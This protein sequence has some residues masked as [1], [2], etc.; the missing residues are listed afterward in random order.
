MQSKRQ[1]GFIPFTSD[2]RPGVSFHPDGKRLFLYTGKE[3]R[4]WDLQQ[5][6]AIKDLA[7]PY[8]M[9]ANPLQ[10]LGPDI[11]M[12]RNSLCRVGDPTAAW[13]YAPHVAGAGTILS[14]QHVGGRRLS[15]DVRADATDTARG[16]REST[17]RNRVG[18]RRRNGYVT[19][20]ASTVDR[21][22]RRADR[23][24]RNA[25]RRATTDQQAQWVESPSAAAKLSVKVTKGKTQQVEYR[26]FM[27]ADTGTKTVSIQLN[28]T[29]LELTID[30]EKV[31]N[32][33]TTS[34]PRGIVQSKSGQSFQ[35][36]VTEA[37]KPDLARLKLLEL[38]TYLPAKKLRYGRGS[39]SLQDGKW[40]D[41]EYNF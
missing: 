27:G 15:R 17:G 5:H 37:T 39:S 36:A 33:D 26:T 38:P 28:T 9:T 23:P 12:N 22:R 31:W 2:D 6:V 30:G 14:T 11:Y 7:M 24:G 1:V 32:Y 40:K 10:W 35:D 29:S 4:I 18:I 13:Q 41:V 16:Q 19:R 25:D 20:F 21:V 34:M 3:M 8:G